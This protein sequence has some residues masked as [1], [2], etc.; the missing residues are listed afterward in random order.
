MNLLGNGAYLILLIVQLPAGVQSAFAQ[1]GRPKNYDEYLNMTAELQAQRDGLLKQ[2]AQNGKAMLDLQGLRDVI[3][4]ALPVPTPIDLAN[5]GNDLKSA[6]EAYRIGDVDTALAKF[7]DVFSWFVLKFATVGGNEFGPV[8][9]VSKAATQF[10]ME[11]EQ[12]VNTDNRLVSQ[13]ATIA[14]RQAELDMISGSFPLIDR[15]VAPDRT[16]ITVN[17]RRVGSVQ[18]PPTR[19]DLPPAKPTDLTKPSP[20]INDCMKSLLIGSGTTY[21]CFPHPNNDGT[22]NYPILYTLYGRSTDKCLADHKA[23]VEGAR[24]SCENK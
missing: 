19:P 9:D 17:Q 3:A 13:L 12:K 15:S 18:P 6:Q 8:H 23:E 7:Y 21:G 5:K 22:V 16:S 14:Q 24:K 4:A 1:N 2:I 20:S 10:M 11:W